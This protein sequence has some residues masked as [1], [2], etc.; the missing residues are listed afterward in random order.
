MRS[1]F[2]IT[3]VFWELVDSIVNLDYATFRKTQLYDV[4]HICVMRDQ[5]FI[6]EIDDSI[7]IH[8]DINALFHDTLSF[9]VS[10]EPGSLRCETLRTAINVIQD[11]MVNMDENS[12][13]DFAF[14]SLN[15]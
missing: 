2:D 7:I 13:L 14:S 9:L 5:G 11:V 12:A 8:A 4:V 10:K 3:P 1:L 15:I 6:L